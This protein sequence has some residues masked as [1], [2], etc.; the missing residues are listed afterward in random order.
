MRS[1]LIDDAVHYFVEEP[2]VIGARA[3]AEKWLEF[4]VDGRSAV[5]TVDHGVASHDEAVIEWTM[6]YTRRPG[7]SA[8]LSRGGVVCLPRRSHRRDSRL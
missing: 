5:W 1:T 6:C 3:I 4:F 7:E 8:G 2:P